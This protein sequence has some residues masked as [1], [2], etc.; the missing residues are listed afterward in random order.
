M[1]MGMGLCVGDADGHG[2]IRK[3]RRACIAAHICTDLS[4][5]LIASSSISPASARARI[6]F[7]WSSSR[8]G[9]G[10]CRWR[11]PPA[12]EVESPL[13]PRPPSSCLGAPEKKKRRG[14]QCQDPAGPTTRAQ[15]EIAVG[16]ADAGAYVQA[17]RSAIGID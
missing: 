10:A 6:F 11:M 12:S 17:S 5:Q 15:L 13:P 1:P 8:G 3:A 7:F 2:P 4:T 14:G 16:D 9:L